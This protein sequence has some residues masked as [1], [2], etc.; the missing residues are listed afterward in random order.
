MI[1][2][3]IQTDLLVKAA[4]SKATEI[5]IS[6]SIAI[7]DAAGHLKTFWRMDG[8]W[9]GSIDVAIRKARTSVLFESETQELWEVCKPT[10]QAHGLESTNDG[11]VTFAGGIPLRASDG[12]NESVQRSQSIHPRTSTADNQVRYVW[13][14]GPFFKPSTE[15]TYGVCQTGFTAPKI[16]GGNTAG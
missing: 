12:L 4:A 8:A 16:D 2:T 1:L 15:F 7:L 11:L 6:A 10:A 13:N 3:S 14:H 5:G 9:L